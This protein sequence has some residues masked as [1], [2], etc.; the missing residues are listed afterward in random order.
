ME[1]VARFRQG[2]EDAF[3]LAENLL[4]GAP[5]DHRG[6]GRKQARGIRML[7]ESLPRPGDGA[8]RREENPGRRRRSARSEPG[9]VVLQH[10]RGHEPR[11]ERI[12]I[13]GLFP[14]AG[15]ESRRRP[16]LGTPALADVVSRQIRSGTHDDE[17]VGLPARLPE[18]ELEAEMGVDHGT[19]QR[20]RPIRQTLPARVVDQRGR[21]QRTAPAQ[22]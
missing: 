18:M 17:E 20:L 16:P 4:T 19:G 13:G 8:S 5:A 7:G 3:D 1:H 14:K 22:N 15:P 11:E 9:D 10:R 21:E 6:K 2:H 12:R